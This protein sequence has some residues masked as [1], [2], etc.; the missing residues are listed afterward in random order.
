MKQEFE[1]LSRDGF[2]VLALAY[3]DVESKGAYSTADEED[4]ILRGYLAFLDPPKE[5][6]GGRSPP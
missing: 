6:R 4:L 5:R 3:K 2:R 1:Q